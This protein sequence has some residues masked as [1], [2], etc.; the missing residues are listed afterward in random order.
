M[1]GVAQVISPAAVLRWL[2]LGYPQGVPPQDR[3]PL[4]A[5]LRRKLTE[6]QVQEVVNS[7]IAPNSDALEDG[8]INKDEISASVLTVKGAEPT[9]SDIARVAEKLVAGGWPLDEADFGLSKTS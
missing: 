4:V 5:L 9:E 2:T 6:E 3:I 1:I 7:L 8:V